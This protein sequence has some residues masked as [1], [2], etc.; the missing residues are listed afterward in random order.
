ML[1]NE[2]N[3]ESTASASSSSTTNTFRR[4]GKISSALSVF[5][6]N[7]DRN[8][9]VQKEYSLLSSTHSSSTT[10]IPITPK[11]A[12]NASTSSRGSSSIAS[13]KSPSNGKS[14]TTIRYGNKNL[15]KRSILNDDST[16]AGDDDDNSEVTSTTISSA[17]HIEIDT[18]SA[19]GS[20]YS[21]TSSTRRRLSTK[22]TSTTTTKSTPSTPSKSTPTSSSSR[23][24]GVT[25]ALRSPPFVADIHVDSNPFNSSASSNLTSITE[26]SSNTHNISR[27]TSLQ[28]QQHSRRQL[29]EQHQK[30]I[31]A[32]NDSPVTDTSTKMSRAS[33]SKT[34]TTT[35]TTTSPRNSS[36]KYKHISP[37]STKKNRLRDEAALH[38]SSGHNSGSYNMHGSG[39]NLNHNSNHTS[40][41]HDSMNS[42]QNLHFT[43]PTSRRAYVRVDNKNSPKKSPSSGPFSSPRTKSSLDDDEHNNVYDKNKMDRKL[44]KLLNN[45]NNKSLPLR[46]ESEITALSRASSS[47]DNN[48]NNSVRSST[49]RT[50]SGNSSNKS[51][52]RSNKSPNM[53]R[54]NKSPTISTTFTKMKNISN[55]SLQQDDNISIINEQL[56]ID[57]SE[58]DDIKEELKLTRRSSIGRRNSNENTNTTTSSVLNTKEQQHD[59]GVDDDLKEELKLTRRSSI[60]RRNSIEHNSNES[61]LSHDPDNNIAIIASNEKTLQQTDIKSSSVTVKGTTT[62]TNTVSILRKPKHSSSLSSTSFEYPKEEKQPPRQQ[63]HQEI[64]Q[65]IIIP[66][67]ASTTIEGEDDDMKKITPSRRNSISAPIQ[68][69]LHA[70]LIS[71]EQ[72]LKNGIM[73]DHFSSS[74][75]SSFNSNNNP[76]ALLS[77]SAS[78]MGQ[79]NNNNNNNTPSNVKKKETTESLQKS[80]QMNEMTETI[81]EYQTDEDPSPKNQQ[82]NE[83]QKQQQHLRRRNSTGTESAAIAAN[84]RLNLLTALNSKEHR[85]KKQIGVNTNNNM[86]DNGM[87][88]LNT[89]SS[90]AAVHNENH[91]HQQE[92]QQLQDSTTSFRSQN[93]YSIN[94]M[95]SIDSHLKVQ[96][97]KKMNK[98]KKSISNNSIVAPPELPNGMI[99]PSSST[100]L[101]GQIGSN[102]AN[103]YNKAKRRNS[104]MLH[105]RTQHN[106]NNNNLSLVDAAVA[107]LQLQEYDDDHNDDVTTNESS[108]PKDQNYVTNSKDNNTLRDDNLSDRK[109]KSSIVPE[110]QE[111]QESEGINNHQ[112]GEII[113]SSKP[114]EINGESISN[115]S[116]N[117]IPQ[118]NSHIKARRR[119]SDVL[120]LRTQNSTLIVDDTIQQQLQKDNDDDN[121]DIVPKHKDSA[122]NECSSSLPIGQ[123]TS[124]KDKDNDSTFHDSLKSDDIKSSSTTEKQQQQHASIQSNQVDGIASTP[125]SQKIYV[126]RSNVRNQVPIMTYD[127]NDKTLSPSGPTPTPTLFHKKTTKTPSPGRR[128]SR[129]INNS[130]ITT[131]SL[132]SIASNGLNVENESAASAGSTPKSKKIQKIRMNLSNSNNNNNNP[133][134]IPHLKSEHDGNGETTHASSSYVSVVDTP[135]T[136][137]FVVKTTRRSASGTIQPQGSETNNASVVVSSEMTDTSNDKDVERSQREQLYEHATSSEEENL[138]QIRNFSTFQKRKEKFVLTKQRHHSLSTSELMADVNREKMDAASFHSSAPELSLNKEEETKANVNTKVVVGI[139]RD[140]TN[141]EGKKKRLFRVRFEDHFKAMTP[142]PLQH[143]PKLFSQRP[144]RRCSPN[145]I[146]IFKDKVEPCDLPWI[147]DAAIKIQCLYRG[148]KSRNENSIALLEHK[149]RW[150]DVR[151]REQITYILNRKWQRMEKY[152]QKMEQ[153]Y[154]KRESDS[155]LAEKL[156]D[157]LSRDNEKFRGQNEVLDEYLIHLQSMNEHLEQTIVTHRLNHSMI[158]TAFELVEQSNVRLENEMKILKGKVKGIEKELEDLD[159]ITEV[160]KA[161]TIEIEETIDAIL[162]AVQ[163]RCKNVRLV[164]TVFTIRRSLLTNTTLGDDDDDNKN[165]K[166]RKIDEYINDSKYQESTSSMTHLSDGANSTL[167]SKSLYSSSSSSTHL[168]VL[169]ANLASAKS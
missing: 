28:Q 158:V 114:S 31:E 163:S 165:N 151:K 160:E 85:L 70:A 56:S 47:K 124:T 67:R 50:N 144:S 54:T 46:T 80:S 166:I 27:K 156:T 43:S 1:Q 109:T 7:I 139:L 10:S 17:L 162:N 134:N 33:S 138:V 11:I 75:N 133:N 136:K 26:R 120:H 6:K 102:V 101:K 8:N 29:K 145:D 99:M 34:I 62:T 9:N 121:D 154:I 110:Q 116:N 84:V 42:Q 35:N 111:Q 159:R 106:N 92:Q 41:G 146:D 125:K 51:L 87:T 143:N 107:M 137:K 4:P 150:V 97:E 45:D 66:A 167:G 141:T 118:V 48:T 153:K 104:D 128:S 36:S 52:V 69:S 95:I 148:R 98:I 91:V 130:T 90:R 19:K 21:T 76:F 22:T 129:K 168:T 78:S 161:A 74:F 96:N 65:D 105:L 140:T 83:Q 164:S 169:L 149:I 20:T 73:N 157:M 117:N 123:N 13:R 113:K 37:T 82:Q 142:I 39:R 94:S 100:K 59:V 77:S 115:T 126:S 147:H 14:N 60:S 79:N 127:D 135:G 81:M 30:D 63:S 88:S 44:N 15:S 103:T 18:D 16:N 122:H 32:I 23:R 132:S 58:S 108:N 12:P 72:R 64:Q 112:G 24:S 53:S 3:M 5:E 57:L 68:N 119:H 71:K 49:Q 38:N 131:P 86:I 155:L 61:S 25:T 89:T 55:R 152:R 93:E 2:I 40:S